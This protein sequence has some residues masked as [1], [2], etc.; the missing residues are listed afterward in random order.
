MSPFVAEPE[1]ILGP[2]A[3]NDPE[4]EIGRI[5]TTSGFLD[6]SLEGPRGCPVHWVDEEGTEHMGTVL[7]WSEPFLF[8]DREPGVLPAPGAAVTVGAMRH[9]WES[10]WLDF[11][12]PEESKQLRWVDLV[13]KAQASGVLVLE[14]MADFDPEVRLEREIDLTQGRPRF[15]A[16]SV[17]GHHFKLRL[18]TQRP[19][20]P[21]R[22]EITRIIVRLD[23]QEMT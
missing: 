12:T 7:L 5:G 9:S 23:E 20:T 2:V 1:E 13:M 16:S 4:S 8:L 15:D 21:V 14:I 6:A 10:G 18:R 17:N 3:S 19:A 11:G 22:F